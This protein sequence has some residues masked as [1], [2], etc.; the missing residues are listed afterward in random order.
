GP[1]IFGRFGMTESGPK[2]V[3]RTP[4]RKPPKTPRG[5]TACCSSRCRLIGS[6]SFR[7]REI[8]PQRPGLQSAGGGRTLVVN[9]CRCSCLRHNFAVGGVHAFGGWEMAARC[10]IGRRHFVGGRERQCR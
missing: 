3:D 4:V 1:T 10:R 2:W 6:R 8:P 9:L 7:D 5:A